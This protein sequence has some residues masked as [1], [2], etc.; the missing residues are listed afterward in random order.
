MPRDRDRIARWLLRDYLSGVTDE[1]LL[2]ALPLSFKLRHPRR[3]LG[4]AVPKWAGKLFELL[5]DDLQQRFFSISKTVNSGPTN[6]NL[7]IKF[8]ESLRRDI[9]SLRLSGGNSHWARY[10]GTTDKSY[11]QTELSPG[12]W[13]KK[14]HIVSEILASVRAKSVL[15]VGANTGHYAKL[16]ADSGA[17]VTACELDVAALTVCYERRAKR[18]IEHP[19][20]GGQCV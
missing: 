15:D 11:F 3:T 4:V 7:K 9:E 12:D 14:Q 18:K 20:V 2:A 13:Q 17:R 5:P 16:A 19:A 6:L 1:D 8:L 10:Y